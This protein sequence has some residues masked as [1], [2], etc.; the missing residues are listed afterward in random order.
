MHQPTPPP[1]MERDPANAP[2][3]W[4]A[5]LLAVENFRRHS[6]WQ[7]DNLGRDLLDLDDVQSATLAQLGD[8]AGEMADWSSSLKAAAAAPAGWLEGATS[9]RL[10]VH[11]V[12]GKSIEGTL[13]LAAVD[14]LVL[15]AAVLV[16]PGKS[17][18]MAGEVF[19]PKAQVLMVQTK[20]AVT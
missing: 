16:E 17:V 15:R 12:E 3:R 7:L 14:G 9:A 4:R 10:V 1:P 6:V 19:V 20:P 11:T 18:P 5:V 13:A 2:R 8:L